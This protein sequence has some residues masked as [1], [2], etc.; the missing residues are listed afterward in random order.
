MYADVF[1][2]GQK[3]GGANLYQGYSNSVSV[4]QGYQTLQICAEYNGI[5]RGQE[6]D[7]LLDDVSLFGPY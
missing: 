2:S 3:T 4:P 7:L 5:R 1:R 6:D